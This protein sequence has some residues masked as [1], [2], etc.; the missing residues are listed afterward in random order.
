M[1]DL[2]LI[3]MYAAFVLG[4]ALG[5]ALGRFNVKY[6]NQFHDELFED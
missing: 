6:E 1:S 5:Y 2:A 3:L 4:G